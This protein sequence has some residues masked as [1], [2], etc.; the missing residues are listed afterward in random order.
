M[1]VCQSTE[2]SA[3][4]YWLIM[5]CNTGVEKYITDAHTTLY[6]ADLHK[7]TQLFILLL[8]AT[9]IVFYTYKS[10]A[11]RLNHESGSVF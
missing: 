7:K 1:A 5:I 8:L 3:T 4:H 9:D 10:T 2:I 6:T 11:Y